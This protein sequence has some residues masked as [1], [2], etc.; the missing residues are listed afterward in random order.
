MSCHRLPFSCGRPPAANRDRG[1]PMAQDTR[2]TL[3]VVAAVGLAVGGVLGVVGTFVPQDAVRQTLWAID[4]VA[5]VVA[6]ALLTVK[7]GR[8]GHDCVA[9]GFLVFV[10]GESLLLAGNAAGLSGSIPSFGGGVALWSASLLMTSIPPTFALWTRI[11][12]VVAAILFAVTAG[13]IAW[14]AQLLP[15][16]APVP[17][18]GYPFLVITFAGWIWWLLQSRK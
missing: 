13:L 17:T 1:E 5:L 14:G 10:T 6:A 11:T 4:G 18:L 3:D 9:A 7:F 16:S 8:Q 15:T 2:S 12:G